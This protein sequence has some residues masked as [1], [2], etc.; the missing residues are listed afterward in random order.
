MPIFVASEAYETELLDLEILAN[1]HVIVVK[2]R[3]V[4]F[5]N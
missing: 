3:T 5:Y 1:P 4:S 2:M